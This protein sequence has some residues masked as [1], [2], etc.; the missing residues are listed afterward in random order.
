MAKSY[1]LSDYALKKIVEPARNKKGWNKYDEDWQ[2]AASVSKKTL[3]RFWAQDYLAET[4]FTSICKALGLDYR[5]IAT[6]NPDARR[7]NV[8]YR[9]NDIFTGRDLLLEQIRS[10]LTS[11]KKVA[12]NQQAAVSGLGGIGKTQIALRYAWLHFYKAENYR[13]VFWVNADS[14][15]TLS[16]SY[17]EIAEILDLPEKDEKDKSRI[18]YAVKNWLETYPDWLLIFDNADKPELLRTYQPLRGDGH[19]LLTSRAQ[20]FSVIGI[21]EAI[22]VRGLEP[23]NAFL[24]LRRRTGKE[25]TFLPQEEEA[26]ARELAELLGYHPLALEQAG[27]FIEEKHARFQDYLFRYKARRIR[28]LESKEGRPTESNPTKGGYPDSVAITWNMNFSEVEGKSPPSAELLRISSFLHPDDIP[29]DLFTRMSESFGPVIE[30]ALSGSAEDPLLINDL[31]VPLTR[32]SLVN[33][34]V[35]ERSFV[36]HR[37]VQEVQKDKMSSDQQHGYSEDIMLTLGRAVEIPAPRNEYKVGNIG[38]RIVPHA[39]KILETIDQYKAKSNY[40]GLS[41]KSIAGLLSKYSQYEG[42]ERAYEAS[43]P[44]LSNYPGVHNFVFVTALSN[45]G[46][47]L[48]NMDKF[49]EAKKKLLQAW[50]LAQQYAPSLTENISRNIQSVVQTQGK[51]DELPSFLKVTDN[52]S[53]S[54]HIQA[55]EAQERREYSKA[56]ELFNRALEEKEKQLDVKDARSIESYGVSL[57]SLVNIYIER[58]EN[59]KA[60]QVCESFIGLFNKSDLGKHK[61]LAEALDCIGRAYGNIKNYDISDEYLC[62]SYDMR[63]EIFGE[64]HHYVALSANNIGVFFWERNI[65]DKAEKFIKEAYEIYSTAF[66]L[67]HQKTIESIRNLAAIYDKLEDFDK[68]IEFYDK[69]I[70]LGFKTLGKTHIDQLETLSGLGALY[71]L[72]GNYDKSFEI[73]SYVIPTFFKQQSE[74]SAIYGTFI[75]FLKMAFDDGYDFKNDQFKILFDQIAR[76]FIEENIAFQKEVEEFRERAMRVRQNLQSN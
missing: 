63:K 36:I 51:L 34:C 24:F 32:Y 35:N 29:F 17:R 60:I 2:E 47:V 6:D 15:A 41:L 49:D 26:A 61:Q 53:Q 4:T 18:I 52:S 59:H 58:D 71:C 56:I 38:P 13:Y 10:V 8:P 72:V 37:M 54:L 30:K 39:L 74:Q 27:A 3:K 1:R 65:L 57:N 44:Y 5:E 16:Q 70:S 20:I 21:H 14:D 45:L 76:P 42:A 50:F 75:L 73:F 25:N 12:I 64:N 40:A 7:W 66:G 67:E 9:Y 46:S 48:S 11:A 55:V 69:A 43:L 19:T 33:I 62:K 23:D 28:Y 68:S 31:V 22:E